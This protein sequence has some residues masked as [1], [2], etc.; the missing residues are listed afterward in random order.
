M[1]RLF[2]QTLSF[3]QERFKDAGIEL[4]VENFRKDLCFDAQFTQV[5]QVLLNLLNNAH[6]AIED[7]SPK[8]VK[9]SVAEGKDWVEMRVTD[10]G[11]GI[12]PK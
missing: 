11:G 9:L 5:S 10:C 2:D 12:I 4:T 3:C 8:W 7:L 6:D 1:R